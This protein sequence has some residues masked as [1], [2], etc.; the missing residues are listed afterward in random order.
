MAKSFDHLYAKIASFENLHQAWRK[1]AKG[2]RGC[3]AAASFEVNLADELI[4]L[5]Q[6]LITQTWQPGEYYSFTIRD[7]K[8]RLVS[9]APFRDRVVHHA[10][11]NITE[12]IYEN[13]FIGDSYANRK[14]KGTH[15][16]LDKAQR[17]TRHNSYVLQCDLRQFFPSVDHN[18]LRSVL[19]RKMD[20]VHVCF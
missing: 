17:L 16:A 9:A 20:D 15:A 14:G 10:L 1:A 5:Q 7:P 18:V 4:R 13:T 11:C 19:F 6:E 2:K 8:K 3:P 12:A